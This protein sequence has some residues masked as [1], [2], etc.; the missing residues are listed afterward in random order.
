VGEAFSDLTSLLVVVAGFSV[1]AIIIS[2]SRV[3][4]LKS[5][6]ELQESQEE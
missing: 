1:Q 4:A 2:L 6:S 5:L 3:R